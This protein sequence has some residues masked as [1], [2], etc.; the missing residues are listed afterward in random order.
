MPSFETRVNR[1][2]ATRINFGDKGIYRYLKNTQIVYI[3]KGNVRDRLNEQQREDWDFDIIEYSIIEKQDEQFEWE[4]YWIEKY[5]E[6]NEGFLP[7]Y[8]LISGNK[9]GKN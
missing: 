6:E 5:K 9:K 8:N 1:S 4:N 3:G 2:D 7:T